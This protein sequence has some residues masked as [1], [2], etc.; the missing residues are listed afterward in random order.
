[1]CCTKPF[2]SVPQMQLCISESQGVT[3]EDL[4]KVGLKHTECLFVL[5]RLSNVTPMYVCTHT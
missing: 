3:S 1:M 5:E 4:V 2:V